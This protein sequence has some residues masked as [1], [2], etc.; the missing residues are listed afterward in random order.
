MGRE[1]ARDLLA[2]V[3]KHRPP[4]DVDE[5]IDRVEK[6]G[7]DDLTLMALEGK[8]DVKHLTVML[9]YITTQHERI[10]EI[11]IRLV[12]KYVRILGT[13]VSNGEFENYSNP[14]P[15]TLQK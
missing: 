12:D 1:C 4:T 5:L 13:D 3:Y 9:D 11:C 8:N 10:V 7:D 15:Y 2:F 6:S 14:L